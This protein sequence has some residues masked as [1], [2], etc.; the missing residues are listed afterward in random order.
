MR[1]LKNELTNKIFGTKYEHHPN[2]IK[3]LLFLLVQ[4]YN[5]W[6]ES[7]CACVRA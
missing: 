4:G 5:L 7:A 1:M 2:K 3:S 6:T